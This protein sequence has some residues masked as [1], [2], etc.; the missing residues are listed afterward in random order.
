[1]AVLENFRKPSPRL[2][3]AAKTFYIAGQ[4]HKWWPNGRYGYEEVEKHDP[5]WFEQFNRIVA[6]A[7]YA[8][9]C[10]DP[11]RSQ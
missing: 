6:E 4:F 3:A 11:D 10:A 2:R 5:N 1:M 7:L 9:D 8:A